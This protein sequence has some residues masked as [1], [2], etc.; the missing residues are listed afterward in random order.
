MRKIGTVLDRWGNSLGVR[1]PKAI[2]ESAGLR[3]GDRVEISFEDAAVVIRPAKPHY[4]L[5]ELLAGI[6]PDNLHPAMDWGPGVG[7]ER[8]GEDG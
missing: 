5:D 1:V 8:F 6:T 4:R 3:E 7:A 2:A